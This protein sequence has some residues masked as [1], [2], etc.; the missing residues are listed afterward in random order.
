L[1]GHPAGGVMPSIEERVASIEERVAAI[2]A[3]NRRVEGDKE[4][5]TSLVR[6]GGVLLVTYLLATLTLAVIGT[7]TPYIMAVIPTLGFFLSTLTLSFVR[8]RW[9]RRHR[10]SA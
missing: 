8:E 5:E 4:W 9:E 7:E 3:R 2:E 10:E 6:R 1:E